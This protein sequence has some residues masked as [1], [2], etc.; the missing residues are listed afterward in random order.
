MNAFHAPLV[1]AMHDAGVLLLTGTDAP[2]PGLVP[3]FSIHDELD[4]LVAAGLSPE[5]ALR[6]ATANAGWFVREHVDAGAPFGT[7]APGAVADLVLVESDP[8]AGLATLRDPL[9]VMVR[10]TWYDRDALRALLVQVAGVPVT[11]R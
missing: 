5:E 6:A 2:L 10:G 1:S 11:D 7:I 4:A 9:G 8:R 3:G